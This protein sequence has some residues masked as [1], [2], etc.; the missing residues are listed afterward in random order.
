MNLTEILI[1][2]NS[3]DSTA[4]AELIDIAYQDLKKLATAKMRGQ[5]LDHTLTATA[6]V[7]EVTLK[8]LQESQLEAKTGKQFYAFASTAMRNY[9]IDHAR[10]KARYKRGGKLGRF[11]FDEAVL[12]CE[13]QSAELLALNDALDALGRIEPRKAQ[14]VEMRYFGGMSNDEVAEALQ[15][16]IATVKRDWTVAK[17]WLICELSGDNDES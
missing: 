7:N 14:V 12:A 5:R 8:L 11:S 17:S 4:R 9:L 3:G 10:G 15:I 6:L 13:T 16:S 2:A 1:S